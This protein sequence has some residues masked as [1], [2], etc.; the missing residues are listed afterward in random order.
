[1][2]CREHTCATAVEG[3][4]SGDADARRE[5][6]VMKDEKLSGAD[7]A[8]V[9][10]AGSIATEQLSHAAPKHS[11]GPWFVDHYEDDCDGIGVIA[12]GRGIV[13]DV[14]SD[15]CEIDELRANANVIAAAPELLERLKEVVRFFGDDNMWE[16][17]SGEPLNIARLKAVI[18]KAEGRM[19]GI[20]TE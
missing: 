2:N 4:C 19:I 8:A 11:A 15:Y 18:A 3:A 9:D 12:K 5:D 1:M 13:A 7:A 16:W 20:G 10:G 6:E 17:A 14:N